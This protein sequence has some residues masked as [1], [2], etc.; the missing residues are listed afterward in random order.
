MSDRVRPRLSICILSWNTRDLLRDCLQSVGADPEGGGWEV[1]VVDNGSVDG[2]P[3]MVR[4][5]FPRVRLI[6]N[7][8]NL[9]FSGGNNAGLA[10]AGGDYLLLL[11]SDTRVAPGT[12]PRLVDYLEAHPGT[13]VV[14]PRLVNPDGSL[15][16]SCGRPPGLG[17]EIVHKLLLHRVFPFFRFGRWN[18]AA[19]RSVGWVTGACLMARRAAVDQV[20]LL[21]DGIYMC[22]ED[23]D[24]CLRFRQA[25]WD[26]V[27]HPV[28]S[29]V[30]LEGQSIRQNLE[31]ML[32]VSQRSLFYLF[33]KHFGRRHLAALRALTVVEMVLRSVLWSG[34]YATSPARRAEA[35]QRLAAY[36]RILARTIADR[37]YWAP[38]GPVQTG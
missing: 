21:D 38:L 17:A 5:A 12:L 13:G 32:V 27:Y 36:R 35:A 10:Q 28:G 30:H 9:G 4:E 2:S 14:G 1:I 29:V 16:L 22:F 33:Q 18:H 8:C 7:P 15:Q 26:V 11:N 31:E 3:E 37:R 24:W 25:G 19:T 20:G 6:V 23:L 34:L